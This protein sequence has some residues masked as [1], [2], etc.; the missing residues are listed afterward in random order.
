MEKDKKDNLEIEDIED[1]KEEFDLEEIIEDSEEEV[2]KEKEC[3]DK[4]DD[5]EE[6]EYNIDDC[7]FITVFNMFLL[8]LALIL[9]AATF[10]SWYKIVTTKS[11]NNTII[12]ECIIEDIY[13][14]KV[15]GITTYYIKASN[16][17]NPI[18]IT[19]SDFFKYK[20]GDTIT[21]KI[22]NNEAYIIPRSE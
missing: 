4:K 1:G 5:F 3:K 10:I 15:R 11:D 22:K 18:E 6:I 2:V 13:N 8:V 17:R 7:K 9:F 16:I 19:K 20:I 14:E 12:Q 21:I